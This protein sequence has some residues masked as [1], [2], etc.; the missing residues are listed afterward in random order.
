MRGAKDAFQKAIDSGH[1]DAAPLATVGLGVLL[2]DQG[3]CG[4]A[5]DAFQKA[6]DS[7]HAYHSAEGRA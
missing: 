4:G 5:K 6:I 1:A 7:G 3:E 2:E